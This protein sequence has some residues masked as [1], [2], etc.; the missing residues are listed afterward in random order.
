MVRAEP[1]DARPSSSDEYETMTQHAALV[2]R[3]DVGRLKV[4]GT[5][6]L[7]LLNRLSTNNLEHFT[8]DKCMGTILTNNKGRIIDL[9]TI[10][11]TGDSLLVLTSPGR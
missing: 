4:S 9:L 11:P 8:P 5:D 7:D 3:S 10:I 6:A 1:T 2:D